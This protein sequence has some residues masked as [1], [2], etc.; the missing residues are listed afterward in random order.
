MSRDFLK[1][2]LGGIRKCLDGSISLTER[3]HDGSLPLTFPYSDQEIFERAGAISE[4]LERILEIVRLPHVQSTTEEVI[5]SSFIT[6]SVTPQQLSKTI[7][8]ASLWHRDNNEFYP[9]KVFTDE[10]TD[11]IVIYE[12][13][14]I[15]E[16]INRLSEEVD[17]LLAGAMF[18]HQTLLKNMN[19]AYLTF[20]TNSFFEDYAFL[21]YPY[22]FYG[23]TFDKDYDLDN[24]LA[25]I[26]SKITIIKTTDFYRQL[27]PYALNGIPYATNILIHNPLYNYCYRF[28]LDNYQSDAEK[29]ST[30]ILY[31]NFVLLSLLG[32]LPFA[33]QKFGEAHLDADN[34]LRFKP[35]SVRAGYFILTLSEDPERLGLIFE[36]RLVDSHNR[37]YSYSS[38]Y[39]LVTRNYTTEHRP[40]VLDS[41]ANKQKSYS[42]SF[43][44]CMKN[45][46]IYNDHILPIS[47]VGSYPTS[48]W[49]NFIKHIT[50]LVETD[51]D[52]YSS[53][54]PVCGSDSVLFLDGNKICNVCNS[55]Y[56][57]TNID[58]KHLIWVQ[59]FFKRDYT[60]R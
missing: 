37:E 1:D 17:I 42:D 57:E 13:R 44:I 20:D 19:G 2:T 47:F 11:T 38:Y 30:D 5:K 15:V 31:Y 35:V 24:L 55:R 51:S 36:S 28:Y 40:A 43:I 3:I 7:Q 59:S 49:K 10:K 34:R 29:V 21:G 46:S 18:K 25:K 52:F 26:K 33:L 53:H 58:S 32:A 8:D 22:P 54:C 27:Y 14:F 60:K 50:F 23:N 45:T 9:E 12:N 4:C 16:L 41:L 56:M 6:P 48:V 39:L